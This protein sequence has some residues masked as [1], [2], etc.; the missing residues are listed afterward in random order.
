MRLAILADLGVLGVYLV[1]NLVPLHSRLAKNETTERL[2][3]LQG[4]CDCKLGHDLEWFLDLG[5]L[6]PSLIL[7]ELCLAFLGLK[8]WF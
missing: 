8:E 7:L 1:N 6:F 5:E 3:R 4:L 2:V